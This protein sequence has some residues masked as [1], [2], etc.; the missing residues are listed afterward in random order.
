MLEKE[1]IT[2]RKLVAKY[3]FADVLYDLG[4]LVW[5]C[6]DD[7]KFPNSEQFSRLGAELESAEAISKD[8]RVPKGLEKRVNAKYRKLEAYFKR[9]GI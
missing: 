2:L 7:T 1:E 4:T 5:D 6:V 9:K 8:L 3:G